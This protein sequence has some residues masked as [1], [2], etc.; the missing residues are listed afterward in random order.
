[1]TQNWIKFYKIS[2]S[3]NTTI[4]ADIEGVKP[5]DTVNAAKRMMDN[6]H[7]G[8]EQVGFISWPGKDRT[9]L[10]R[11]MGGEFCGNASRAYAAVLASE[12]GQDLPW[13]GKIM[14]SGIESPVA[15]Y[16]HQ[17]ENNVDA[18]IMAPI[19]RLCKIE[20][21]EGG[22]YVR[23]PGITHI[24]LAAFK[25]KYHPNELE[26]EAKSKIRELGL[27]NEAAVG[28][29]WF[30]IKPDL[31]Q[32][33][34]LVWVKDTDSYCLETACGSGAIALAIYMGLVK[35]VKNS[36]RPE[37]QQVFGQNSPPYYGCSNFYSI[38]QPSG[39]CLWVSYFNTPDKPLE[40]IWLGGP[41]D[42]IAK[43]EVNI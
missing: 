33:C 3:G 23:L 11:M 42:I 9:R 22:A 36:K 8:A 38:L 43:G 15:C 17:T 29:I 14:T 13:Q 10:L 16:V 32:M 4:L 7:L 20:H 1:M 25:N 31:I 18:A 35:K 2:P 21:F 24:L 37:E 40:N 6:L 30:D 26:A 41:C 5:E 34:P 39:Q 19:G 27:E 12:S 28:C